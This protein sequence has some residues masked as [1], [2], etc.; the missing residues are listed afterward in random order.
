MLHSL[1]PEAEHVFAVVQLKALGDILLTTPVVRALKVAFPRSKVIFICNKIGRLMLDG[2]PHIDQFMFFDR[3][4]ALGDYL[5]KVRLLRSEKIDVLFDFMNN[6]RSAFISFFSG[7]KRK[8]SYPSARSFLYT[9]VMQVK[10]SDCYI[11]EQKLSLIEAVGISESGRELDFY[12]SSADESVFHHFR[13]K[14]G[15]SDD[16]VVILSATHKRERR[17]WP[18]QNYAKLAD[19]LTETYAAVVVWSWGP[20]EEQFVDGAIAKCKSKSY[21]MPPTTMREMAAFYRNSDLFVGNSNGPSH[22]A[23]A[24]GLSSIQLHGHTDGR[25]WCPD[26]GLHRF[27]QSSEFGRVDATLESITLEDVKKITDEMLSEIVSL[28]KK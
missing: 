24:V 8:V 2:N 5:K 10:S 26:N 6:P 3:T 1:N 17:K 21:K 12:F 7:A 11:V 28:K 27:I 20:G 18:V 23:V 14:I 25:S 13:E 15:N 16:L 19:Y 9:D 4:D 22:V